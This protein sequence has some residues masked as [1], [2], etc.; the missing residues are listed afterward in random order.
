MG[1]RQSGA[2]LL[3][4]NGAEERL[5]QPVFCSATPGFP[6][7]MAISTD[8]FTEVSLSPDC[9]QAIPLVYH[10]GDVHFLFTSHVVKLKHHRIVLGT[11]HT[12]MMREVIPDIFPGNLTHFYLM[13]C[14]VLQSFLPGPLV[15]IGVGDVSA[16]LAVALPD[17]KTFILPGELLILLPLFAFRTAFHFS[18]FLDTVLNRVRY[19]KRTALDL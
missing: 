5:E 12:D 9:L 16:V 14:F 10:L 4:G 11:I 7:L 1:A 15:I 18:D 6:S 19:L 17:P 13:S 8:D 3:S 2:S